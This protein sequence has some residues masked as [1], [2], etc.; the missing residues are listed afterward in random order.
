MNIAFEFIDPLTYRNPAGS[1]VLKVPEG[2][3]FKAS[4]FAAFESAGK[5][6]EY[7]GSNWDAFFD[8]LRDFG[9]IQE[10]KIVILHQDLPL[11]ENASDCRIY[12]ETLQSAIE[13]WA[14]S[15]DD[16]STESNSHQLVVAFPSTLRQDISSVLFGHRPN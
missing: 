6:P 13:D 16:A 4:L 3:Q 1:F 5:F 12:L 9:W 14:A 8:C 2:I 7:F 15:V 11:S 10:K